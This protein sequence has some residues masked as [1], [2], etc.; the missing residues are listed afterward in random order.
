MANLKLKTSVREA[1]GKNKVDKLREE[2]IV[3]GVIYQRGEE[4]IHIQIDEKELNKIY[5]QAGTS[6]IVDIDVDGEERMVLFKEV[7]KHPF[8][9]RY[10]HVDFMGIKKG[11]KVTLN[12]PIVLGGRDE[13]R[14]Q[15]SVLSQVLDEVEIEC[16]PSDIPSEA[17][18]D[19]HD[20]QIGDTIT[21]EDL[22]LFQND[23]VYVFGEADTVVAS[24]Q[25]P[26]EET[27]DEDADVSAGDVPTVG[28]TKADDAE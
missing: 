1:V 10:V 23:K 27:I 21:L 8:K 2:K 3:P 12:V 24:L 18:V 22:D 16:L 20:M 19:V 26:R 9:N 15:P 5:L 11:Q 28:E 6:N 14:V 25:E 13:I 4:T 17:F 7:Q